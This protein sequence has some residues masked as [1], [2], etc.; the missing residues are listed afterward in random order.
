MLVGE[1]ESMTAVAEESA[2]VAVF[3]ADDSALT[4]F[5]PLADFSSLEMIFT[6][7]NFSTLVAL[8][9]LLVT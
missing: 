2:S 5:F 8:G 1:E 9:H 6:L 7:A 4:T 3:L